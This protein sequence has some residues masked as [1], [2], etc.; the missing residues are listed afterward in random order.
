MSDDISLVNH[1]YS[2]PVLHEYPDGKVRVDAREFATKAL[3][4]FGLPDSPDSRAQ[5]VHALRTM[6]LLGKDPAYPDCYVLP[7]ASVFTYVL[8]EQLLIQRAM[9]ELNLDNAATK[10]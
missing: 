2:V 5:V 8:M 3:P 6:G 4:G 7:P 1:S 10:H 9:P